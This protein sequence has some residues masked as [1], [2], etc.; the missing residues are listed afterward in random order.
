MRQE[1]DLDVQ[2]YNI[3]VDRVQKCVSNC[4]TR[5]NNLASINNLPREVVSHIFNNTLSPSPAYYQHLETLQLVCRAWAEH[6]DTSPNYWKYVW[7]HIPIKYSSKTMRRARGVPLVITYSPITNGDSELSVPVL[8]A[9]AQSGWRIKSF[10][11][12]SHWHHY[13]E[14]EVTLLK[15][16][17]EFPA[18]YL[19]KLETSTLHHENS[20][21]VA[22]SHLFA[23]EAPNLTVLDLGHVV[24]RWE[25]FALPHLKTLILGSHTGPRDPWFTVQKFLEM[26]SGCPALEILTAS[27]VPVFSPERTVAAPSAH[28]K[29]TL[30]CLRELSLSF[31]H[32]TMADEVLRHLVLPVCTQLIVGCH[33]T[34]LSPTLVSRLLEGV[35]EMLPVPTVTVRT[36]HTSMVEVTGANWTVSAIGSPAWN[37][38]PDGFR[39]LLVESLPWNIR[40]AVLQYDTAEDDEEPGVRNT[41]LPILSEAFPRLSELSMTVDDDFELELLSAPSE[42]GW[43]FPNL[44]TLVLDGD[45]LDAE[46]LSEVVRVAQARRL[47]RKGKEATVAELSTFRTPM[48]R[49]EPL[50]GDERAI[51]EQMQV[52]F[53]RIEYD[54]RAIPPDSGLL[55]TDTSIVFAFVYHHDVEEEDSQSEEE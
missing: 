3:M 31:I 36:S 42:Q 7:S 51:L 11:L 29:Y 54:Q 10:H 52:L 28:V 47:A 48:R 38:T 21:P 50:G 27:N 23:G 14:P 46:N 4:Y 2:I 40:N 19:E 9:I 32:P 16:F 8:Q 34:T 49:V 41:L 53:E 45:C 1:L 55:G 33:E 12:S 26:L 18:P 25:R 22:I 6:I 43:L 17:F 44:R 30:E 35:M 39:R 5:R 20:A 37:P 13:T 24:M 15:S